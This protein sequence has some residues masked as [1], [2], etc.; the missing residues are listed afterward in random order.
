MAQ[1][2]MARLWSE[3]ELDNRRDHFLVRRFWSPEE[4]AVESGQSQA[5][6]MAAIKRHLAYWSRRRAG[7]FEPVPE[8]EQG[9]VAI[10][11]QTGWRIP[12]PAVWALV[13][14]ESLAADTA[15]RAAARQRADQKKAEI[16]G[17]GTQLLNSRISIHVSILGGY[18]ESASCNALGSPV[19]AA[20]SGLTAEGT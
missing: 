15:R 10:Q 3:E 20:H 14:P 5:E 17:T 13:D 7:H 6:I 11:S 8:F 18:I 2:Q 12:A 9:L 16:L 1:E 19:L 4:V